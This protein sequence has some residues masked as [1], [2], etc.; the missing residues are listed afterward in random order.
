MFFIGGIMQNERIPILRE[1]CRKLPLDSGVYIMRDKENKIIYIGKAKALKNRVSSYF[2]NLENHLPKVYQM[3]MN[4]HDFD[5]I[6]TESEFEALVLECSLI[7]QHTPKYNILLKDDKGYS[8]IKISNDEYPRITEEKR[9]DTDGSIYIGPY[10]SSFVV[11]QTVEEVVKTFCL[12]TCNRNF[13]KET[14]RARPCLRYHIKQCM[15][16]CK[17]DISPKEYSE[18]IDEAK[19][20]IKEGSSQSVTYLTILMNQAAENLEFEKAARI[21]DRISALK[22]ITSSQKVYTDSK[23]P[24]D[25][26]GVMSDGE[27]TV[28]V[29]LK[30]RNGKLFDKINLTLKNITDLKNAR[31]HILIRYYSQKDDIPKRILLDGEIEDFELVSRYLN[32]NAKCKVSLEI[33]QKGEILK[34][35]NMATSNAAQKLSE[36]GSKTAKEITALSQLQELLSLE[37]IPKYIEAYDISNFGT[38]T[39]VGGMVVFENGKPLKKAYKKFKIEQFEQDDYSAMRNVLTRRLS[40]YNEEKHTNVG[41]GKLPDLIL[42]DG[43]EGHLSAVTPVIESF[44]LPIKVFGMVKDSKHKTRAISSKGGEI[45]ISSNR[46]VFD[47]ITSI[48]DEVHR[49]SITFS[50]KS[51]AKTSFKSSLLEISGVGEKKAKAIL[52]HFKTISNVKNATIE[53]LMK[54]KGV[55]EPLAKEI[56]N[57]YNR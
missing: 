53:E 29:I 11:K 34:V 5:Y 45:A 32:E 24:T 22:K 52:K 8:Y 18:I 15:A 40:H 39:I 9:K 19:R 44:G 56:Q 16:P 4:V 6:V 12:P 7:K 28:A 17:G 50:R 3:V 20:Y 14:N 38:T 47:L 26:L 37:K 43:G 1:K 57:F 33:P 30:F 25:A 23:T 13:S 31:T 55:N 51:H 54:I 35:V 41:F 42:L 48:Q 2:R 36:L 10:T 49:F 46:A 27:N 21:R